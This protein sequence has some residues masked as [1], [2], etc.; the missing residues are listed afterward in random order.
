[1]FEFPTSVEALDAVPEPYR[2]LYAEGEG[3]FRLDAALAQRLDVSGLT[4]ALDKERKAGREAERQLK[5]WTALGRGPDE[6]AGLLAAQDDALARDA[7][8]K[9]EWD[10]LKAQIS[11][12]HQAEL[13]ARDA[14]LAKMRAGLERQ[15]VDAA[16]TAEVAAQKGAAALLLPHLRGQLKLVEDEAGGFA[17]RVVDASG[18]IRADARGQPLSVKDLVAELRQSE[19]FARAFDGAGTSGGGMP[20]SALSGGTPGVFHLTREQ[21][22]DPA[23]YRRARDEA[24][25]AGQLLTIVE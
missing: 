10:K 19:A 6:I 16:A 21:A 15:L 7:E 11:G 25:R 13:A 2:A 14:A 3:G 9:G 1:M 18:E 22:R 24:G 12:R 8:R 20:P 17:V 4:S 5:A 23:A